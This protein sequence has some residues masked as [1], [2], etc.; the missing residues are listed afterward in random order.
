MRLYTFPKKNAKRDAALKFMKAAL[1][2]AVAVVSGCVI[3]AAFGNQL[4]LIGMWMVYFA[5]MMAIGFAVG[6]L[7]YTIAAKLADMVTTAWREDELFKS[8]RWN[9]DVGFDS[10]R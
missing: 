2:V 7:C 4:M 5:V 1:V 9:A 10:T 8:F 3:V 6:S